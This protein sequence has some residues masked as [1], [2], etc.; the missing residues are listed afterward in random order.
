MTKTYNTM[1]IY[2]F[3][4]NE[5]INILASTGSGWVAVKHVP[6]KSLGMNLRKYANPKFIDRYGASV[7]RLN[8]RWTFEETMNQSSYF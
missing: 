6:T 8:L 5:K 7:L 2:L 1:G 4:D 3:V